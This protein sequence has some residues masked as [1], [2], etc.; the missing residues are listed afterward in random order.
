MF[1]VAQDHLDLA[2]TFA[3]RGVAKQT[4]C[5]DHP[6]PGKFALA[7]E[8]LLHLASSRSIT[9]PS[10]SLLGP[11]RLLSIEG[12]KSIPSLSTHPALSLSPAHA[13]GSASHVIT[14]SRPCDPPT[15]HHQLLLAGCPSSPFTSK[16]LFHAADELLHFEFRFLAQEI[17]SVHHQVS[18]S[19]SCAKQAQGHASPLMNPILESSD[20][21][22]LSS[23]FC[24][25][26]ELFFHR[27]VRQGLYPWIDF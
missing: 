4:G 23:F 10:V 21:C 13:F 8:L 11:L 14:T 22:S 3:C 19:P 9:S 25:W 24:V 12:E 16:M 7:T 2:S 17:V 15:Q 5:P 20:E 1:H 26:T 18:P 27:R 6:E